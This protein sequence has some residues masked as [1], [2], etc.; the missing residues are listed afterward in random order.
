MEPKIFINGLFLKPSRAKIPVQNTGFLFGWGIFETMRAY[1]G[2]VYRISDHIKRLASSASFLRIPLPC[3]EEEI[4]Q[5]VYQTLKINN[6]QDAYIKIILSG[7]TYSGKLSVP[8]TE[9]TFI[10]MS[11]PIILFPENWY[12]EGISVTFSSIRR[13]SASPLYQHKTLNFL[14]NILAKREAEEKGYQE[15]IFLNTQGYLTEGSV[16]N[17]FLVKRRKLFTPSVDCGLLP[18]ITRQAVFEICS[19][20]GIPFA[21]GKFKPKDIWDADEIFLT[22]SIREILPVTRINTHS[23]GDGKPGEITRLLMK[24]YSYQTNFSRK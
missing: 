7:G 15:A 14:E 16:T 2:F 1:K 13:N 19:H 17:I 12:K 21:E 22:N 23:V 6:L 18:G 5:I 8:S 11:R 10:V 24:E 4:S 9:Y 20:L 3:P